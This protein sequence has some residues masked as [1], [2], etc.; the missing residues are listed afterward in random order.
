[1]SWST[2]QSWISAMNAADY[3]GGQ[4]RLPTTQDPIVG[5]ELGRLFLDVLEGSVGSSISAIHDAY[6]DQAFTNIQDGRYWSAT[7]DASDA[8]RAWAFDFSNGSEVVADANDSYFVW[9]IHPALIVLPEPSTGLLVTS[10]LLSL[11]GWRRA[12]A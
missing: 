5:S 2:A 11:V 6:Y 12:R 3:E 4:W 9:P 1:M 8:T 7:P 10:G